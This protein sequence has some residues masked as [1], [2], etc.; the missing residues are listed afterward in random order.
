MVF[1]MWGFPFAAMTAAYVDT[2]T[3]LREATT[4]RR[5][6]LARLL[7]PRI[8]DNTTVISHV[9]VIVPDAGL[10]VDGAYE[11]LLT[12]EFSREALTRIPLAKKAYV[13]PE[14]ITELQDLADIVAWEAT[15]AFKADYYPRPLDVVPLDEEH[16]TAVMQGL[17]R[18]MDREGNSRNMMPTVF[19]EL[20]RERQRALAERRRAAYALFGITPENW[21][22]WE[23]STFSLWDV[24]DDP[25]VLD[26]LVEDRKIT[27]SVRPSPGVPEPVWPIGIGL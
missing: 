27:D 13:D 1:G 2:S 4:L 3:R 5:R 20:S 10:T 9:G 21:S 7:I 12:G 16:V 25:A 22:G 17:Q 19:E 24:N 15:Q 6:V 14:V 18:E 26:A 8:I 23:T 11:V